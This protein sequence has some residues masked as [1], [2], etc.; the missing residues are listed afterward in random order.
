MAGDVVEHVQGGSFQPNSRNR[1]AQRHLPASVSNDLNH[2]HDF[3]QSCLQCVQP[4]NLK[5]RCSPGEHQ[6]LLQQRVR[7]RKQSN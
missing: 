1:V 4:S 3:E 6:D 5:H 7:L 2:P